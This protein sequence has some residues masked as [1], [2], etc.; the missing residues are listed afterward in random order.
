MRVGRTLFLLAYIMSSMWAVTAEAEEG[1]TKQVDLSQHTVIKH[2]VNEDGIEVTDIVINQSSGD[3]AET[4][5]AAAETRDSEAVKRG[6]KNRVAYPKASYTKQRSETFRVKDIQ[7]PK[8]GNE[9]TYPE[10]RPQKVKAEEVH[11]KLGAKNSSASPESEQPT[12][13]VMPAPS[14]PAPS[15][16]DPN[17]KYDNGVLTEVAPSES[18]RHNNWSPEEQL[19]EM[20]VNSVPK[21]NASQT[22]QKALSVPF[23]PKNVQTVTKNSSYP[24]SDQELKELW[25]DSSLVKTTPRYFID[26]CAKNAEINKYAK[27][28]VRYNINSVKGDKLLLLAFHMPQLP[29]DRG[30]AAK[31]WILEGSQGIRTI[32]MRDLPT[33]V[34]QI[35]SLSL[36][37]NNL[38]TAKP[39]LDR[40]MVRYGGM[41]ALV[42]YEDRRCLLTGRLSA[43]PAGFADLELADAVAETPLFKVVPA[44]CVLRPGEHIILTAEALP[45]K[46]EQQIKRI[47]ERYGVN[48]S[49]FQDYEQKEQNREAERKKRY[50]WSID[51]KGRLEVISDNSAIYYAPSFDATGAQIICREAESGNTV[52]SSVYVT[53]MPIGE[54][55]RLED[56]VPRSVMK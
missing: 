52:T 8:D 49:K 28:K 37:K 51:G 44:S 30:K 34:Y 29:D 5:S 47:H 3:A 13:V 33:G 54:M 42:D 2:S 9:G 56:I 35:C 12:G 23:V 21:E 24:L 27:A 10:A 50:L 20:P 16:G 41:E 7:A 4:D 53:T 36:D 38:P 11:F 48:G 19:T 55:P 6:P 26:N 1:G 15:L 45:G 14:V 18:D 32:D 46:T 39:N 43:K 25:Q 17:F 22:G 31:A 40:F